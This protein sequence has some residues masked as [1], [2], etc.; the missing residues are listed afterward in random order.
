MTYLSNK[1]KAKEIR[2]QL[3]A[4]FPGIKFWVT[5][6]NSINISW[7]DG[8]TQQSVD[9]I[10]NR[11]QSVS[12]DLNGEILSGGNT[13]VFTDRRYSESALKQ[14]LSTVESKNKVYWAEI[15]F[16]AVTFRPE[17]DDRGFRILN[18]PEYTTFHYD[19]VDLQNEVLQALKDV[20]FTVEKEALEAVTVVEPTKAIEAT[21]LIES[22]ETAIL[23]DQ[24]V[25]E[26]LE[27]RADRFNG[28]KERR[29][30]RY[31]ELSAKHSEASTAAYNE[32]KKMAG[33]IPFG[34]PIHVGHYSEGR[35]RRYRQKIWDKMS[36]SVKH[37]K[38]AK[39]YAGKVNAAENNHAI[40][41][42]DPEAIAK[43]KR[44][45][46]GLEKNQEAM[47]AA[48]KIA[49]SKKLTKD[50]K[51]EALN[52][53]GHDGNSLMNP[54]WHYAECYQGF[55]LSNNNANINRLKKRLEQLQKD[56]IESVELGDTEQTYE[57]HG[58]I[59][60]HARS[61]NRLQLKFN[62][63]PSDQVRSILKSNGF[64]WAPSE[65]AWQRFLKNSDYAL[66]TVIKELDALLVH[67]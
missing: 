7:V 42:D 58:I 50:E 41:S 38:T 33:I 66:A 8:P 28:R 55:E 44:E 3:K 32:S 26:V 59:V 21:E 65:M 56:L 4:T 62:G 63:K 37:E 35:D 51:I 31:E 46:E 19:R 64:R 52:A 6:K 11:Y 27:V 43:I 18:K 5:S 48:N 25:Q 30:E 14:G 40:S 49:K 47:K 1:E 57:Q 53:S 10:A 22:V 20:D 15:D 60:V 2:A 17:F 61:I 67:A 23:E 16:A 24:R 36:Q 39:Y 9:A 13:Y 45:I 54:R 34:Q 12:R 29:I